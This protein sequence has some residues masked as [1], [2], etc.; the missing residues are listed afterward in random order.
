MFK[1]YA[2]LLTIY[3]DEKKVPIKDRTMSA[4]NLL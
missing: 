2:S 4:K 3:K 1:G